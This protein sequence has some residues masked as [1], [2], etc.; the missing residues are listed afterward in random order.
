M[1]RKKPK[2]PQPPEYVVEIP[3]FVDRASDFTYDTRQRI[4]VEKRLD[5][6]FVS[7]PH[8]H[9]QGKRIVGIVIPDSQDDWEESPKMIID[10]LLSE[11]E[12]ALIN[13]GNVH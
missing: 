8:P 7:L 12:R 10:E 6:T 11:A 2:K 5:L 1:T 3:V 13:D 4:V 9:A